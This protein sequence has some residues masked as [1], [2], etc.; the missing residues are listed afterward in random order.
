MLWG[1]GGLRVQWF[2]G[3]NSR[4]DEALFSLPESE[5]CP[6]ELYRLL[7]QNKIG[8]TKKIAL[9]TGP[10]TPVAVIALRRQGHHWLPMTQWMLP[11][12]LFPCRDGYQIQA[13][14][15]LGIDIE[16][17]WWR[18]DAPPPDHPY[19]RRIEQIPTYRMP[20]S[21]NPEEFWM[22]SGRIREI[23]ATRKKCAGLTMEVDPPG[24]FEWIIRNWAEKWTSPYDEYTAYVEDRLITARYL[25]SKN[26]F[27]TLVLMDNGTPVSGETLIVHRNDLVLA[28]NFRE[29]AYDAKRVGT[30][31]LDLAFQWAAA[32][33]YDSIDLGGGKYGY[34]KDW[35]PQDGIRWK[36]YMSP[37]GMF[38]FKK[39]IHAVKHFVSIPF[40][41]GLHPVPAQRAGSTNDEGE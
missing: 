16:V 19:I 41:I 17:G 9:I 33:R 12:G 11:G 29:P 24:G 13:I 31:I 37:P 40:G 34:K 27:H 32:S 15:A 22:K 4:L 36:F 6:R 18:M 14:A 38:F 30:R 26:K 3:W 8:L 23:T 2:S 25:A 20:C 1:T 21:V 5:E 7:A 35:A 10:D 28:Y 39:V